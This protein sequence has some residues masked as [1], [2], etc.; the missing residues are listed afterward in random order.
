MGVLWSHS[1]GSA[2]VHLAR[3]ETVGSQC[4]VCDRPSVLRA[5]ELSVDQETNRRLLVIWIISCEASSTSVLISPARGLS[6]CG[7]PVI[8]GFQHQES[9]SQASVALSAMSVTCAHVLPNIESGSGAMWYRKINVCKTHACSSPNFYGRRR[10]RAL[11]RLHLVWARANR[12]PFYTWCHTSLGSE[13]QRMV[14][15]AWRWIWVLLW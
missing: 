8:S 6:F 13:A 3:L 10:V 4:E 12:Q 1:V 11:Y 9:F 14:V 15:G 2:R 7:P 5:H